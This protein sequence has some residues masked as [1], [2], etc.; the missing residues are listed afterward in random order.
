[1]LVLQTIEKWFD[2][3]EKQ[4]ELTKERECLQALCCQVKYR[5]DDIKLAHEKT[6]SGY[7]LNHYDNSDDYQ[8]MEQGP[9]VLFRTTQRPVYLPFEYTNPGYNHAWGWQC[10]ANDSPGWRY[11]ELKEIF[12]LIYSSPCCLLTST[13]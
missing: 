4:K 9:F 11:E 10:N 12:Y 13:L 6:F 5:E 1:M 7:S 3:Q 2:T 8:A